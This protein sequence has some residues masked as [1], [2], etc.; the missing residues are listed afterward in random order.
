MDL[1]LVR[2]LVAVYEARSVTIAA[3]RLHVT[4]PAISQSLARL[5]R[6]LDDQ[7]FKRSGRGVTPTPLAEAI[8]PRLQASL[9]DIDNTFDAVNGFD[10]ATSERTF[11]IAMSELGEVGWLPEIFTIFHRD[12]PRARL[13]VVHLDTSRLSEWLQVGAI[14]LAITPVDPR[15]AA[16]RVLVKHQMYCIVMSDLNELA[17]RQVTTDLYLAARRVHVESDSGAVLLD[18]A[19][20][21]LGPITAPTVSVQHFAT[22]PPLLSRSSELIAAIPETIAEAWT[23]R[24]PLVTRPVPFTMTPIALNLYKRHTTHHA[25]ALDWFYSVVRQTVRNSTGE[26]AVMQGPQPRR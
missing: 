2:V 10:P 12:A 13:E 23:H 9:A 1:N 20:H 26:F 22:L 24:W 19:H 18:A 6:E 15:I 16:E 7:L 17:R 11:R 4:A 3:E 25:G 21:Q 14:D 5:R 8:F